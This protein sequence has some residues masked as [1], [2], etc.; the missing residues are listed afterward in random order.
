MMHSASAAADN[1]TFTNDIFP[2]IFKKVRTPKRRN[3]QCTINRLLIFILYTHA[4]FYFS[5]RR[6]RYGRISEFLE[7]EKI[8]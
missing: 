5:F 7:I 4:V 2:R 3:T 1:T 6:I 8:K